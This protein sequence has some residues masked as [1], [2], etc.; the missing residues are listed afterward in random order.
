MR[1]VRPLRAVEAAAC[2]EAREVRDGDAVDLFGQN[3]VH[4]LLQ[5]GYRVLQPCGQP[6]RDLAEKDAGL[7]E[8][9]Q[10]PHVRV[11]PDVSTVIVAGPRQSEG[12]KHLVGQLRR[13]EDFIV[14]EVR[15]AREDIGVAAAKREASLCRAHAASSRT[16][17]GG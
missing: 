14:G 15:Y 8:R 12:V 16:V 9:V 11:G 5:V 7:G 1:T 3:V 6:T 13:G 17:S 10:E 4:P 2:K